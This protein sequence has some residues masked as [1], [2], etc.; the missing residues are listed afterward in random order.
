M[1]I[2]ILLMIAILA[3][4]AGAFALSPEYNDFAQGPAQFLMTKDEAAQ[5]K[6][7]K[8][9]DDAK[10]FVALFWARRDPT[11]ATARNEYKEQ[12][13]AAVE[14]AD[15]NLGNGKRQRGAMTDRGKALI[16]YGQPKKVERSPAKA[17]NPGTFDANNDND[18]D[19]SQWTQW[20]YEGDEAKEIFGIQRATL[21]FTDRLGNG[22]FR[23]D[24]G[25]VD[26]NASQQRAIARAIKQPNLTSAPAATAMTTTTATPAPM[27]DAT[28]AA[29]AAAPAM[30]TQ[31]TT[32]A[33][34]SAVDAFKAAQKN[35]YKQS[36]A[37]WGE[38][39]TPEGEYY[40]PVLLYV[41]KSAGVSGAGLT[42]FGVV[43][44]AS[45]K[46]I[47]A[48]EEPATLTASKD[49]FY[50]DRTLLGLP[51][52]KARGIFG[53]AQN[54]TP[55]TMVATDM[56]LAGTLDK[57]SSAVSQ[58]LLSNNVYPLTTAQAQTDPFA[59]GGVKVIPKGDKIFHASDELWYFFEL[60][61]PGIAQPAPA[62]DGTVPVNAAAGTPK[63]QL[64]IDVEGTDAKGQKHKMAAP[65]REVEAVEM[66]GVPGHYGI[67][68]AIPLSSFA[69]GDY[70]FTV[71]VID[72]VKKSSYT[73]SDKFKVV[74]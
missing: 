54:G 17:N 28:P 7:I 8:T 32:A 72:T 58:L 26:L 52:G 33:L 62:A 4:T 68:S 18:A 67:G 24:R 36:Y 29:V 70:T 66:K 22:D 46:N 43:Q 25:N 48:F 40:V 38:F 57:S 60:R 42:F 55:V 2:R 12:F 50:V 74:E 56:N 73:I 9:D 23:A 61:N 49:D 30:Q 6:T 51:A 39:V 15:K 71:K 59:F 27:P 69:P 1:K 34:A 10:A 37:T 53:L 5:W 14:Y 47:A 21:R 63:I 45:G 31:L 64:K 20:I 19:V 35:P 65:P 44:D 3:I 41:P 16:L 11:P 13:D